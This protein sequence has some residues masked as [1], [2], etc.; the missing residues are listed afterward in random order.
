MKYLKYLLITTIFFFVA[1]SDK[2]NDKNIQSYN[3]RWYSFEMIKN[4]QAPYENNCAICHGLKGEGIAAK[5]NEKMANGKYP[6]PPLNM[7]AHAWHHPLKALKFTIKNGGAIVGGVMPAFNNKLDD[8]EIDNIIAYMQEFW[9]DD[10]YNDW[11][12]RGGLTK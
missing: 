7:E 3:N 8:K 6:P 4:G 1:C 9:D 2:K 11:L 12:K 10:H 5:W